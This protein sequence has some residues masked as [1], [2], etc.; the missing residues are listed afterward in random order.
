MKSIPNEAFDQ[1]GSVIQPSEFVEDLG[2]MY[3]DSDMCR[4]NHVSR[5]AFISFNI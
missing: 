3:I 5:H 2:C 1:G 4:T